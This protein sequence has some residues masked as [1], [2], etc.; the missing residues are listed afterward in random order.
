MD[1]EKPSSQLDEDESYSLEVTSSGARLHA[2]TVVGAMHGLETLQQLVQSD[3][4][5][6]FRSRSV[7]SRHATFS[8]ARPHDRL[9]TPL[10]AGRGPQAHSGRDGR[11]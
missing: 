4:T 11:S 1:P 5:E 6:L 8:L 9:R 10:H 2:A 7:D 3:A